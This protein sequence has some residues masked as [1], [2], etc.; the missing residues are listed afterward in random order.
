MAITVDN[1]LPSAGSGGDAGFQTGC[2]DLSVIVL[3]E[4]DLGIC[5]SL[6]ID[7]NQVE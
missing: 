4:N 1:S 7:Y 2:A 3:V 5:Q 6:G